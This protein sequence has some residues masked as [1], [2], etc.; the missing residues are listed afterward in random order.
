MR[1]YRTKILIGALAIAVMGAGGV[2]AADTQQRV[3]P[4]VQVQ[5]TEEGPVFA[6][7]SGMSLYSW[8]QDDGTPGKS[9]CNDVQYHQT[10]LVGGETVP[11]AAATTRKTCIQKWPPFLADADAAPDGPWSLITRDDGAKQWAYQGH[12]LYRSIK[13]HRAGDLNWMGSFLTLAFG[14]N[15]WLPAFAPLGFPA[16]VKLVRQREGLVLAAADDRLLYVW[17]GVQQQLVCAGCAEELQPLR[18]AALAEVRGDWSIINVTDGKQYAFKGQPLYFASDKNAGSEIEAG[19]VPAIYRPTAGFPPDIHTRFSFIGDIYTTKAGMALYI[20]RCMSL[21]PDLLSCDDPGDAA[22][23]RA[24]LCGTPAECSRRWR[25]LPAP[26]AGRPVGEW[27]I[28]DVSD[29]PFGDATGATYLPSE[30]PATVRAWAYRGQPLHTFVDDDEPGQI[31]GHA[32]RYNGRAG[33]YA[34]TVPG[35]EIDY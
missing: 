14:A 26:A 35:Q 31:L 22:A 5:M 7:A 29:P 28:I 23:Y 20:Y 32:V 10:R 25:P 15:A 16:G 8:D 27:S 19:W 21:A 13:D 34:V 4:P 33:F 24:A 3:G 1:S 12:P 11:L 18:A 6:T 17:S 30:A 9:Q 2:R